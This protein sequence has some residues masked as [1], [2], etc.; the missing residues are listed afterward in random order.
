MWIELFA[1]VAAVAIFLSVAAIAM[2]AHG[3]RVRP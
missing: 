2:E 1:V 3:Q